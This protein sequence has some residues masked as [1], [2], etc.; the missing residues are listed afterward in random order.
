MKGSEFEWTELPVPTSHT[1]LPCL[2][3]ILLPVPPLVSAQYRQP[4]QG[5]ETAKDEGQEGSEDHQGVLNVSGGEWTG[6]EDG[7]P[8]VTGDQGQE[9]QKDRRGMSD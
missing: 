5:G 1:F 2:L 4:V 7:E 3:V 8:P 6:E 9:H